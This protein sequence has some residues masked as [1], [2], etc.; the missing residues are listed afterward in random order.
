[1][2]IPKNL[3][4]KQ[5]T[6]SDHMS[7]VTNKGKPLL[8]TEQAYE[9][10][11]IILRRAFGII[12]L[13]CIIC[14]LVFDKSR[15]MGGTVLFPI[16][17]I[18]GVLILAF[19]LWYEKKLTVQNIALLIIAAGFM[20]RLNYVIYTPLSETVRIRQHDL[21]SF[22]GE[23]GHSAY[24]EHFYNNGYT[25]PNFDPTEKAQFYHPPLHHL[26]CAIW[27]RILTTF[28]MSYTRAIGSLQ[29]LSLFYS[30]SCMLVCELIFSKL[31]MRGLSNLL[32]L[33]VIAF[34][35]TFIILAG[36]VNN[37]IL[38][39]LFTLLAVYFVFVWHEERTQKNIIPIALSI[40]L[41]MSTKLSVGLLAIPVGMLFLW[42]FIDAKKDK[43]VIIRQFL[44]F[45][46]I[47]IPLG[48]WFSVRNYIKYDVPFTYVRRLS[49][50]SDQ[51]IGDYS[52]YQRLFDFSDRPFKNVFLNRETTGADYFE[53]NPLVAI[54]K[55]SMFGEYNFAETNPNI[56]YFCWFL[57]IMNVILIA[58]SIFATAYYI[59]KKSKHTDTTEKVFLVFYQILMFVYYIKFCFDFPHNCSMDFRYI[60]PTC[61]IGTF[62]ICA[63]TEHFSIELQ[64]HTK[65]VKAVNIIVS[66][67]VILFCIASII[68]FIMLGNTTLQY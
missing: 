13:V 43:L 68:V 42:D 67:S 56:V 29:Y 65:A 8:Q 49:D 22:G 60:V 25:L 55:T 54:I 33:S 47:C 1:M 20:V 21:Y 32:A 62:F 58:F 26:L 46:V 9:I 11:P 31:R 40:G 19:M 36:S 6:V 34:H 35:P 45:G 66:S 5:R 59:I 52:V 64:S 10:E 17:C 15:D 30:S 53:Y 50:T 4:T 57:L 27:M 23:K 7:K 2:S 3:T 12:G 41:G 28:G 61:V 14:T 39:I 37:D 38:S 44:I 24:I 48:L 16:A 51:Y 63:S 18:L